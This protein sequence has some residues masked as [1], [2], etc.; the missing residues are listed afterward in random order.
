MEMKAKND[1]KM[2]V[3]ALFWMNFCFC[4]FMCF[5]S[6]PVFYN[7][8][9]CAFFAPSISCQV[10]FQHS[11]QVGSRS[12]SSLRQKL[13]A[14]YVAFCRLSHWNR[15]PPG[16]LFAK[17]VLR[18]HEQIG[19]LQI[20]GENTKRHTWQ[21]WQSRSCDRKSWIFRKLTL[22]NLRVQEEPVIFP[23]WFTH[24]IK[25]RDT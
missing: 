24:H 5:Q 14:F 16:I 19:I 17:S 8:S 18:K 3:R 6:P 1:F 7:P 25:S 10:S 21:S 13:H 23:S 9:G 12:S 2:Y 22:K 11:N 4:S 20:L 15:F